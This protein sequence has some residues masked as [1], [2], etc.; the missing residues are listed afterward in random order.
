MAAPHVTAAAALVLSLY[1]GSPA[2][3]QQRLEATAEDLGVAGK[4]NLYGSGLVDAEKAVI[5]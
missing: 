5:Q 3:V 4:D 2:E 1:P